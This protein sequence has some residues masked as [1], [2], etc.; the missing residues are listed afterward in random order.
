MQANI[1][2][3]PSYSLLTIEL[4]PGESSGRLQPVCLRRPRTIVDH[5][6]RSRT[7][8]PQSTF[9]TRSP[10]AL[11]RCSWQISTSTRSLRRTEPR[12]FQLLAPTARTSCSP[13]TAG[14]AS[15]W[16]S[17]LAESLRSSTGTDR[18]I[19]GSSVL[20]KTPGELPHLP[21]AIR[22]RL[23]GP[24]R[25]RQGDVERRTG[26][27]A[28]LE[29]AGRAAGSGRSCRGRA[30]QGE[31]RCPGSRS[32]HEMFARIRTGPAFCGPLGAAHH[33]RFHARAVDRRP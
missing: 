13:T 18:D 7:A 20:H 30:A 11:A 6:H 1:E 31:G 12:G 10:R 24:F 15:A 9:S 28:T 5:R 22:R 25:R 27:A 4:M 8:A 32:L 19:T 21:R 23:G 33:R 14:S 26:R 2:F 17:D 16:R 29:S 3:D